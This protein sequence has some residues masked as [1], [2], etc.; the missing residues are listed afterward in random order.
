MRTCIIAIVSL[1]FFSTAFAEEAK[2]ATSK[3]DFV[4]GLQ[5]NMSFS[6]G[7]SSSRGI[8]GVKKA[9]VDALIHFDTGSDVILPES[10]KTLDGLGSALQQELHDARISIV[11]HTDDRGNQQYNLDLS[12]RRAESVKNYLSYRCGI[13]PERLLTKGRGEAEPLSDNTSKQGRYL[14][15]RVEFQRIN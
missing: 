7:I 3:E 10:Y 2:F 12:R 1:L 9:K 8:S 6:R 14:N 11:G 4:K 5:S 13:D 15:R